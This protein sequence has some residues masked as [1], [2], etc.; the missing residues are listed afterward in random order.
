VTVE[1]FK[2]HLHCGRHTQKHRVS[3]ELLVHLHTGTGTGTGC[4]VL[5]LFEGQKAVAL[6]QRNKVRSVDSLVPRH[7]LK[8]PRAV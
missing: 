2:H 5:R 4:V 7:Q 1:V 3:C 8:Q 6:E